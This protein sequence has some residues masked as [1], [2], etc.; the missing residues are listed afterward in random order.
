MQT[1]IQGPLPDHGRNLL[2]KLGYGEQRKFDGQISYIR[3][4][5]SSD[6]PRFHAYIEDKDNGLQINLHLDQKGASHEGS[7]AHSGEY[8]GPL[9]EKE[10]Q[11]IVYNIDL[12]KKE[13]PHNTPKPPQSSSEDKKS[14]FWG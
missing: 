2:R 11:I 9:V 13:S 3:R 10:M 12:M 14:K 1:F 6:F 5:G 8:D 7:H 4:A